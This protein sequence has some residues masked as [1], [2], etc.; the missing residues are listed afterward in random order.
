MYNNTII[1]TNSDAMGHNC[2]T[3][4]IIELDDVVWLERS[5]M[6]GLGLCKMGVELLKIIRMRGFRYVAHQVFDKIPQFN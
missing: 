2:P 3:E 6:V 5:E 1:C 4:R